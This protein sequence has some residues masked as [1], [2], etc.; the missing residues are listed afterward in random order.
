MPVTSVITSL[1]VDLADGK[2]PC[3]H[4]CLS[5]RLGAELPRWNQD[6]YPLLRYRWYK[7]S[8]YLPVQVVRYQ[9]VIQLLQ[10]YPFSGPDYYVKTVYPY[11]HPATHHIV[12][13]SG[14]PQELTEYIN[15]WLGHSQQTS[16][17]M[18]SLWL[19]LRDLLY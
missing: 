8:L 18:T 14:L 6:E 11:S 4:R 2:H 10:G 1:L 7:S 16:N 3:H 15:Q 5:K 17:P 19:L 13:Q 9:L 12:K